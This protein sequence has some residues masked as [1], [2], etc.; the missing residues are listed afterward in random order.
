MSTTLKHSALAWVLIVTQLAFCVV[1]QGRVVVCHD[2]SGP[3]HIEFIHGDRSSSISQDNCGQAPLSQDG[4]AQ[5]ICTGSPCVDEAISF[6]FTV[7]SRRMTAIDSLTDLFPNT[8]PLLIADIHRPDSIELFGQCTD[9]ETAFCL[10]EL[11]CSIR[12]TV[13]VL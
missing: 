12:T 9:F 10:I 1:G 3:S 13:L 4:V 6:A 5:S 8:P 7:N 2:E 11:Q